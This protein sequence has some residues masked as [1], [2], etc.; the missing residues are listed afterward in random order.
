MSRA[1]NNLG[2]LFAKKTNPFYSEIPGGTRFRPPTPPFLRGVPGTRIV[3]APGT[4]YTQQFIKKQLISLAAT[5]T[6]VQYNLAGTILWYMTSTNL[7]DL[8]NIRIG[9]INADPLPFQPGNGIEGLSYNRLF[10]SNPTAVA[11]ATA[12]L[13]YF[14][15][16]PAAPSRF[17]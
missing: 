14:K 10:I 6:D 3:S 4:D 12:T 16:D 1:F 13:V 7:T 15:D 9:D 8:L 5:F 17:F 2:A 11:G